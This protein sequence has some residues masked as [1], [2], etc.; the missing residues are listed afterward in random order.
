MERTAIEKLIEWRSSKRRKL[1]I[2]RG[3]RQ[4]GKTW[5]MKEFGR[6]EF[7][8]TVYVNFDSNT[9]MEELFSASLDPSGLIAGLEL[10]SGKKIDPKDTLI[11]FDEVQEV[12][13]A[14]ASLKYFCEE[15]PQYKIVC[16]GSLLGIA[17]HDK[18][19]FPVGK[20]IS[21]TFIPCHSMNF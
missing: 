21:W 13:R 19:S 6:R 16:A 14:L 9:R 17:L 2:I 11:I 12:P 18:T 20:W 1:L 15:A 3:A 10:F 8:D 5:L 4:V 7:K